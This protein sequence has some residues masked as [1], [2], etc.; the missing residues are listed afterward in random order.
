MF[1]NNFIWKRKLKITVMVKM[2]N[3][4]SQKEVIY[5]IQALWMM[6]TITCL[7]Q[8]NFKVRKSRWSFIIISLS[9]SLSFSL[10]EFYR[11]DDYSIIW[12][13]LPQWVIYII[14]LRGPWKTFFL[15]R[16]NIV[17]QAPQDGMT[18]FCCCCVR[19]MLP[20][21]LNRSSIRIGV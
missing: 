12:P 15:L 17:Q 10:F 18:Y 3:K 2:P 13:P 14:F 20:V 8:N 11:Y 21:M 16:R 4:M 1:T 7:K 5:C 19:I 6:I 9:L